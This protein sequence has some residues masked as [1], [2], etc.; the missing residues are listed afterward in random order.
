[1]YVTK[2]LCHWNDIFFIL[3]KFSSLGALEV[4]KITTFNVHNGTNFVKMTFPCQCYDLNNY[5]PKA[6]DDVIKWKHFPR[7]WPIVRGIR[8][9]PVNS[10]HKG[11]WRGAFLFAKLTFEMSTA[12]RQQYSFS[13][14]E[15]I[16]LWAHLL[17]QGLGNNPLR[18]RHNGLDSVSNLQPHH[19]LFSRLFRR[20]SKKT[21][22][23]RVTGLCVGNSPGTGEFP[24]QMASNAQNVSIWWRHHASHRFL[25]FCWFHKM[26]MVSQ[27]PCSRM[28][29]LYWYLWHFVFPGPLY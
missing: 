6:H 29:S 19:C 9:S 13:T 17:P 21:P 28:V 1:M 8:R 24:A 14:Y 11:Q 25:I 10:P 5:T 22:K 20:T 27:S 23:L 15:R 16:W 12:H 18:W 7:F 3:T 2:R 26:P 4:V